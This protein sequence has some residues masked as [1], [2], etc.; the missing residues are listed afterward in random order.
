VPD[1]GRRGAGS[2]SGP[3]P[4]VGLLV[5]PLD[6]V[7]RR[8]TWT[9]RHYRWLA[10][11]HF[12]DR[13]LALTYNHYLATVRLRDTALESVEADLV[14]WCDRDPFGAQVVRLAAYR[15]V[16]RLGGLCLAARC[17]TGGVSPGPGRS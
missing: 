14:P 10:G 15:G 17:S 5:A 4:A 11:V 12:E 16:T 7:A 1:P 3:Q 8:S 2:H 6:G 9:D 13:A